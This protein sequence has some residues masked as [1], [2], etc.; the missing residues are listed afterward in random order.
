MERLG[1]SA[2]LPSGM[3]VVG[4]GPQLPPADDSGTITPAMASKG[5]SP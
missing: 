1:L 4:K 2:G 3:L 5:V